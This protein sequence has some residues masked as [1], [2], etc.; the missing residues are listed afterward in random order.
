MTISQS[1]NSG[2][3]KQKDESTMAPKDNN[4]ILKFQWVINKL[5]NDIFIQLQSDEDFYLVVKRG[6]IRFILVA[7]RQNL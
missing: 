6:F 5:E 7:L 1:N 4:F 2:Y 3:G